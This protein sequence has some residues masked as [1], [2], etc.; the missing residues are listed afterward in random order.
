MNVNF[1]YRAEELHYLLDNSD[2]RALVYLDEFA[3]V[4]DAALERMPNDRAAVPPRR[5]TGLRSRH[6]LGGHTTAV[7]GASARR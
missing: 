6:R 5:G 3:P 7:A 2:A 4:V 1:R